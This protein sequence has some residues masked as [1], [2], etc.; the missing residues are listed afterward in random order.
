MIA[1]RRV[2][3]RTG[4]P[5]SFLGLAA[6]VIGALAVVVVTTRSSDLRVSGPSIVVWVALCAAANVLPVPSAPNVYLSMSSPVNIAIAALCP[7]GLAAAIVASSSLS[8]WEIRRETTVLHAAYN[9]AQLGLSSAIA[10]VAFRLPGGDRWTVAGAAAAVV[11]YHASNWGFVAAAETACRRVPLRAALRALLPPGLISPLAYFTLGLMG[12]ALAA[13]YREVGA[14]AV[15]LLMLP[16]LGARHA[17]AA[18]IKVERAQRAQRMLANRLI[19]ER[20]RERARIAAD[21][22]DVV[23]Q[24]LAGVQLVSSNVRS[25]ISAGNTAMAEQFAVQ[26]EQGA[27]DAVDS[28]RDSIANLRRATLDEAG[29]ASTL[30]RYARAF[31]AQSGIAV[32]LDAERVTELPPA[33]ALLLYECYQELLRNV[34]RHARADRVEVVL[35]QV[36]SAVELRVADD[37]VGMDTARSSRT[38]TEAGIGVGLSLLRDKVELSGGSIAVATPSAG[39]TEVVVTVPLEDAGTWERTER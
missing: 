21:I 13:T 36:G 11:A 14:W 32:T 1:Q 31:T 18:S 20:E 25:A 29:I 34:V 24:E 27:R 38:Q 35:H 6:V 2:R 39:G 7:P 10:G 8:E 37:G 9:R 17:V 26:L 12:V 28:L 3:R 15:A 23:L 5:A 16:L 30:A 22:H 4:D 19:D 33:V